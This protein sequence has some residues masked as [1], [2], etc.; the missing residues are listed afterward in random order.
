MF[1]TG[2]VAVMLD[3]DNDSWTGISPNKSTNIASKWL[4]WSIPRAA[5]RFV[6]SVQ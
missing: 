2:Q 4:V 5:W 3:C 6:D 1:A